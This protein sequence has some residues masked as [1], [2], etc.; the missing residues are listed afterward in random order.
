MS[1]KVATGGRR[2]AIGAVLAVVAA[3]T[4]TDLADATRGETSPPAAGGTFVD[5][6]PTASWCPAWPKAGRRRRRA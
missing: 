4:V 2:K 6:L 5:I 3:A 1:V